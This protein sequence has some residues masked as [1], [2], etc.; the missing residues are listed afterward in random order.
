MAC[1]GVHG[2]VAVGGLLEGQFEVEDLAGVDLPVPD[3]VDQV[4]QEPAD[5][6]GAA[7]QVHVGEEQLHRRAAA[8]RG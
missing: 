1:A 2:P 7:V 6:G 4:G 3:P 8:R 5:R